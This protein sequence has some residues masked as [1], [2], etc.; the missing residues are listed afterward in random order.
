M[1]STSLHMQMAERITLKIMHFWW[2]LAST[3]AL[4]RGIPSWLP[5]QTFPSCPTFPLH[6]FSS[7]TFPR[8]PFF[9]LQ[10]PSPPLSSR[11]PSPL[12][13]TLI[14]TRFD[15]INC[16]IVGKSKARKAVEISISLNSYSVSSNFIVWVVIYLF[17]FIL[18]N[19]SLFSFSFLSDIRVH[20]QMIFTPRERKISI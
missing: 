11:P 9:S 18:F 2:A 6:T 20:Q 1:F 5:S 17:L 15:H 4:E 10:P 3:D 7:H 12:P 13:K 8:A 19:S 16:Y 14:W